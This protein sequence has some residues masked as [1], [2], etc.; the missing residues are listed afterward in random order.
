MILGT[1]AVIILEKSWGNVPFDVYLLCQVCSSDCIK[2]LPEKH[3]WE[4]HPPL[5]GFPNQE[6]MS[7]CLW[8]ESRGFLV[9]FKEQNCKNM[10]VINHQVYA[11]WG[12]RE[13]SEFTAIAR[14]FWKS[15]SLE[16]DRGVSLH[17]GKEQFVLQ[18][19]ANLFFENSVWTVLCSNHFNSYDVY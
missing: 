17:W 3:V 13:Y 14:N 10:Q 1:A 2:E 9:I 18:F 19:L 16:A 11:F 4:S 12:G 8:F 5:G 15:D 6:V 7:L